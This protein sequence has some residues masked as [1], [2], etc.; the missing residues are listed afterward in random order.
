[1][2]NVCF[3]QF[4]A[5]VY[6]VGALTRRRGGLQSTVYTTGSK[7]VLVFEQNCGVFH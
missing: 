6:D 2:V 4:R 7:G 3:T 1:M 5:K